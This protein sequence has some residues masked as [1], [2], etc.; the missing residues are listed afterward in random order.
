M[1]NCSHKSSNSWSGCKKTL[2]QTNAKKSSAFSKIDE[3]FI[4]VEDAGPGISDERPRRMGRIGRRMIIGMLLIAALGVVSQDD[5]NI[6]R[7]VTGKAL[8][9]LYLVIGEEERKIRKDPLGT[10]SAILKKVFGSL[11]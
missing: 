10:G 5:A 4:L 2:V 1:P 3:E 6:Q 11:Q 9:G 7:Y 8:D